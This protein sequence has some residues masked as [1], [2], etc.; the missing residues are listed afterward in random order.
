[1]L[2]IRGPI[3]AIEAGRES[4]YYLYENGSVESCG[5][6]D[7]G[8]LADGTFVDSDEPVRVNIPKGQ[9]VHTIGSGPSSQSVFFVTEDEVVYGAG[10]NYRFQL[11]IGKIGSEV[12]PV[13]VELDGVPSSMY[14]ITKV[15]SSGTHTLLIICLIYTQSPTMH[16]T[17][18]PTV[19]IQCFVATLSILAQEQGHLTDHMAQPFSDFADAD[20]DVIANN[21]SDG[22]THHGANTVPDHQPDFRECNYLFTYL[23]DA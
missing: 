18:I 3:S 21:K 2:S 7:E 22:R 8:Q 9:K 6:N 14:E 15:S 23:D 12:F 13:V 4:S 20:T 16:P 10:Q 19:S 11:G 17:A 1:M 5:R